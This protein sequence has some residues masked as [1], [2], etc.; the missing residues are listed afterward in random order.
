MLES[1]PHVR[2]TSLRSF[3]EI[4]KSIALQEVLTCR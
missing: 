3:G 4:L 1:S 2:L